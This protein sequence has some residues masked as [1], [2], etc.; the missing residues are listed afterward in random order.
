[1]AE[2]TRATQAGLSVIAQGEPSVR[3]TQ[4][5]WIVIA[6]VLDASPQRVTQGGF[7]VL[8]QSTPP[9]RVTQAGFVVAGKRPVPYIRAVGE[10]VGTIPRVMLTLRGAEG[11]TPGEG[12]AGATHRLYK[13]TTPWETG[14]ITAATPY[15]D[16]FGD[17]TVAGPDMTLV[18]WD[19]G[20]PAV[21][22]GTWYYYALAAIIDGVYY[23]A[24]A[25]AETPGLAAVTLYVGNITATSALLAVDPI[26]EWLEI[27]FVTE[28][29]GVEV[30]HVS[31]TSAFTRYQRQLDSLLPET[32]YVSRAR[33]RV[34]AGWS[35]WSE[36]VTWETLAV[37]YEAE[38]GCP[39]SWSGISHN[40][41]G[42]S[43]DRYGRGF[44]RPLPG[45]PLRG[46][47]AEIVF[48]WQTG[49]HWNIY[50]SDD[51]GDTWALIRANLGDSGMDGDRLVRHVM[52]LDTTGYP[53]GM[54][55]RLRAVSQDLDPVVSWESMTFPVDNAGAVRWW[56]AAEGTPDPEKWGR[57]WAEKAAH[58]YYDPAG[59][60]IW[61]GGGPHGVVALRGHDYGLLADRD[62]GQSYGADV[63]VRYYIWSGEGGLFRL[64]GRDDTETLRCGLGFLAQGETTGTR[65]G[66][67]VGL[68]NNHS[69]PLGCCTEY[70]TS[71]NCEPQIMGTQTPGATLTEGVSVAP[72]PLAKWWFKATTKPY[73]YT[74]PWGNLTAEPWPLMMWRNGP[75]PDSSFG[76]TV[77]ANTCAR[78]WEMY[79]QRTRV[80]LDPLDHKRVR[81]R[82]RWD[83]PGIEAPETGYW[84][85]DEWI[86]FATEWGRGYTGLVSW[87]DAMEL[88]GQANGARIF[89]SLSVLPLDEI[90]P[91]IPPEELTPWNP[92]FEGQPCTVILQVFDEDRETVKWEVGDD[93]LH[94]SPFLCVPE[95]YGEQELDFVE[96][97]ATIGQVEVVLIDKNQTEGDQYSGW[98]TERLSLG[99][100]GVIH[101]RRCRLLRFI[102]YQLGWVVIADGPA[103]SPRMDETYAA[104]RWI[105]RDTRDTERKIRAFVR[106]DTSWLLPMGVDGGFGPYTDEDGVDQWLVPP[107]EPLVG[108]Y[109]YDE[110]R[111]FPVGSVT[112]YGYWSG[113][114]SITGYPIG[115]QTVDEDV[116]ISP[117]VEEAFMADAEEQGNPF[118]VLWTWPNLEILWRLAGSEDPWT[119]VVPTDL[120]PEGRR[121]AK[122]AGAGRWWRK[123][124]TVWDSET[125]D[126]TEVRAVSA[127]MLRGY[128]ALGTFPEHLQDIEV[129]VRWVGEPTEF[130][131]L[132]IEGLTDGE[133]LKQLYDGDWSPPDPITGETEPTGIRYQEEDL[134]EMTTPVRL[135]LTAPVDD[136]REWTEKKL[137]APDGWCPALDNDG[138]ISPRT[139]VPPATWSDLTDINNGITEPVPDWNAGERIVNVLDFTYP[140]LYR[141]EVGETEAIDRLAIREVKHEYREADEA[142]IIRHSEQKVSY[143]G[144]AFAALGDVVGKPVM[145]LEDETGYQLSLLRK[146]HIFDRY[147]D[148]AQI[149]QVPVMR[150][151]TATLRAGDWVTV[152]LTWFPDYLTRRRRLITGAQILAIH[153]VDC[154]WRILLLEEAFPLEEE[155]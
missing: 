77:T 68:F 120:R 102:S 70:L 113:S 37:D 10:K 47:A 46:A 78:R 39:P 88:Y 67:F 52:T 17:L 112:F 29:G 48:R 8:A 130:A 6:Q 18:F 34:A 43:W 44:F 95:S 15:L 73:Q 22:W 25:S 36:D 74:P 111:D 150:S 136:L 24:Y 129:A 110:T 51:A 145:S 54:D 83:G 5:G 152:D 138:R 104:Y 128:E 33:V 125:A 79:S 85:L 7:Q 151:A 153:D 94:P 101:G 66:L 31:Q 23:I 108:Q 9:R 62:A 149:I 154:A 118:P 76:H 64:Q 84:H 109:R 127:M 121:V 90:P 4:A 119:V 103:S 132:H 105:I 137:Y 61:F 147:K 41:D 71:W 97:A 143:E 27:E 55:Y 126:G 93:P 40:P 87:Q 58:T 1:M 107:A 99:G 148:G 98:M 82:V 53:D 72:N 131:P 69:W 50:L 75:E 81:V 13:S 65:T 38:L 91:E 56:K 14:A 12:V 42:N 28:Q 142:S 57:L 124:V 116:V 146:L 96:G 86:E 3:A 35:E 49:A 140:R 135:R 155:S 45:Q 115:S 123:M 26:P 59:D 19:Y 20:D 100:V 114:F 60:P 21:Q 30:D 11:G 122:P 89:Y 2:V 141:V 106:G 16:A 92:G 32:E 133:L 63:T 144:D 80:E 117:S 139:Q 134:L